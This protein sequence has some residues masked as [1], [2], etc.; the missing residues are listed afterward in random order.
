VVALEARSLSLSA[1]IATT[2]ARNRSRSANNKSNRCLLP[3]RNLHDDDATT[4]FGYKIDVNTPCS[5]ANK[6]TD[7][8]RSLKLIGMRLQS[9]IDEL[10]G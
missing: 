9:H 5:K 8:K 2:L 3:H 6:H 4:C 1:C 10:D 7:V